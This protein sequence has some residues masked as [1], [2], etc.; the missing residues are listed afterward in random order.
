MALPLVACCSFV[1]RTAFLIVA[2]PLLLVGGLLSEVA[3]Q[4][5]HQSV[6]QL[7]YAAAEEAAAWELQ[8]QAT[9]N[10][11]TATLDATEAKSLEADAAALEAEGGEQEGSGAAEAG[12][13]SEEEGAGEAGDAGAAA[14][15]EEG[16]AE[17][18][19]SAAEVESIVDEAATAALE[20]GEAAGAAAS[21]AGAGTVAAGAAEAAVDTAALGATGAAGAAV[22]TEVAVAGAAATA[23]VAAPKVVAG[24]ESEWAAA[25]DEVQAAEDEG[26]AA[27]D[28][29][30]AAALEASVP[31][32][33]ASSLE[34]HEASAESLAAAAVLLVTS[35]IAE[36]LALFCQA[37]IALMVMARWGLAAAS[38]GLC[39]KEEAFGPAHWGTLGL[40]RGSMLLGVSALLATSWAELVLLASE[41][42]PINEAIESLEK[43]PELLRRAVEKME[44]SESKAADSED[45][46]NSSA[47]AVQSRLRR[48]LDAEAK[49]KSWESSAEALIH[50]AGEKGG[51][52]ASKVKHAL[53]REVVRVAR[54]TVDEPNTA[55]TTVSPRTTG[56]PPVQ[57]EYVRGAFEAVLERVLY[58]SRLALEGLLRVSL[59]FLVAELIIGLGRHGSCY[60][61]FLDG[62]SHW[63]RWGA[64]LVSVWLFSIMMAVQL[65]PLAVRTLDFQLEVFGLAL[66]VTALLAAAVHSLLLRDL[67]K[68]G[69]RPASSEYSAVH[70]SD[71]PGAA[72]TNGLQSNS[73]VSFACIGGWSIAAIGA[74]FVALLEVIE[75]PTFSSA[76]GSAW[77]SFQKTSYLLPLAPHL[78]P[79]VHRHAEDMALKLL[80][81]L[82]VAGLLLAMV[83]AVACYAMSPKRDNARP[84]APQHPSE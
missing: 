58:W 42:H 6:R 32:Y 61:A 84:V 60:P 27:S 47:V 15:A 76:V 70:S 36:V 48:R 78:W 16:T 26:L 59:L 23:A 41:R 51:A 71:A 29:A 39:L 55:T 45:P 31:V 14:G 7:E 82:A 17:G 30:Q 37:P 38:G 34:A 52:A 25:S 64:V 43:V 2:L 73:T 69:Q 57:E 75:G 49:L 1:T 12:E 80:Q 54:S 10:A 62:A 77:T 83:G 8:A 63:L 24:A 65:E 53:H 56:A 19:E 46:G 18:V 20:S 28:E 13:G 74:M 67:R 9:R 3:S 22:G 44:D 4:L 66:V 81:L 40:S 33:E 35:Q 79:L 50:E 21:G 11:A 5:I 72:S 68:K